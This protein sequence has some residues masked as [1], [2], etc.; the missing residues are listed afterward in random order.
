M[1]VETLRVVICSPSDVQEE[2]NLVEQVCRDLNRTTAK[3]RNLRLDTW[4]WE[5]DS[6]PGFHVEGGQGLIDDLM[7]IEDADLVI[8]IF[9]TRFGTPTSDGR[10]GTE[11][12]LDRAIAAWEKQQR[13][14]PMLF[15]R[16]EP[17]Q[18]RGVKARA[19]WAEV[20]AYQEKIGGR[21][22]LYLEYEKPPDFERKLRSSFENHLHHR[23]PL[24]KT[25]S[26]SAPSARMGALDKALRAGSANAIQSSPETGTTPETPHNDAGT[27]SWDP[28]AEPDLQRA[29][30]EGT[31]VEPVP[32]APLVQFINSDYGVLA[33]ISGKEGIIQGLTVWLD[34]VEDWDEQERR[35]SP[36]NEWQIDPRILTF[37]KTLKGGE[38]FDIEIAGHEGSYATF[39]GKT[40]RRSGITRKAAIKLK[41]KGS[42]V[43]D[44]SAC[45]HWEAGSPPMLTPDPSKISVYDFRARISQYRIDYTVKFDSEEHALDGFKCRIRSIAQWRNLPSGPRFV[46]DVTVPTQPWTGGCQVPVGSDIPVGVVHSPVHD[47]FKLV[48]FDQKLFREEGRYR[49][50]IDL[51]IM[52]VRVATEEVDF[53]FTPNKGFSGPA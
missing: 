5:T 15:F 29:Y 38:S 49:L 17:P 6:Y 51:Q 47:Y 12:E 22:G 14:M 30:E 43:K 53:R 18:L 19:Q 31:Y 11:H 2:R 27:H 9:W 45:F 32:G 20:A 10:T 48:N 42:I 13:P 34:S 39:G 40:T 24:H 44:A 46:E 3:D 21:K 36:P 37:Q 33:R 8:G 25:A 50:T 26:M 41:I 7:Q 23:F 52:G 1:P 4:R 16:T 28:V 35:W